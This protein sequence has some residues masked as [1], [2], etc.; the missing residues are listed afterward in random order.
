MAAWQRIVSTPE[1]GRVL[2][3][4]HSGPIRLL[5]AAQSG[6]PLSALLSIDVPHGALISIECLEIR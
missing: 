1:G 6:I 2:I 5:R 3:V 4:T